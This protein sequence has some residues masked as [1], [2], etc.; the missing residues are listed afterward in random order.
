MAR[1]FWVVCPKCKLKFYAATDDF[2]NQDRKLLCPFCD[3]RFLDKEA[4]EII[5]GE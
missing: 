5:D 2:R 4:D 3:A 1:I